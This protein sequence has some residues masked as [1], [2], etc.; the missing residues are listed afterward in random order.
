MLGLLDGSRGTMGRPRRFVDALG[1]LLQRSSSRPTESPGPSGLGAG[2]S[3]TPDHLLAIQELIQM[4]LEE[5]Y[6]LS[7]KV[8]AVP[9]IFDPLRTSYKAL[10]LSRRQDDESRIHINAHPL[11]P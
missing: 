5:P 8:L 4:I 11:T 7:F 3:L 6:H 1:N 10:G 2:V 9:A